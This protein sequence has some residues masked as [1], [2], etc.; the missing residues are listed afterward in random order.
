MKHIIFLPA[1][2]AVACACATEK[3]SIDTHRSHETENRSTLAADTVWMKETVILSAPSDS[4]VPEVKFRDRILYRSRAV[5]DTLYIMRTDT[6][7]ETR[8]I[9]ERATPSSSLFPKLFNA[10]LAVILWLSAL[11]AWRKFK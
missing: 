4:V 11:F 9:K 7:H 1:I 5:H 10:A 8:I 2:A 3:N 6:V